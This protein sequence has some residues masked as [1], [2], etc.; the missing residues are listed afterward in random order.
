M[1]KA[2]CIMLASNS[3]R[4]SYYASR[5]SCIMPTLCYIM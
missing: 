5:G 4:F 1:P 3:W 2:S